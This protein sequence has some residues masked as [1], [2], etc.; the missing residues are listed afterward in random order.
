M[1]DHLTKVSVLLL[2]FYMGWYIWDQNKVIQNQQDIIRD[3][4]I[5]SFYDAIVLQQLRAQQ[6]S[7]FYQK[8]DN[9]L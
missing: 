5:Q 3:M 7:K 4:Q 8:H 1:N 2:M 9:P 6:N